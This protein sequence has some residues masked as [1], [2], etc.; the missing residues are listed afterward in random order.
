VVLATWLEG[1]SWAVGVLTGI[2]CVTIGQKIWSSQSKH[3]ACQPIQQKLHESDQRFYRVLDQAPYVMQLYAPDGTLR[4]TNRSWETLWGDSRAVLE[5]Y[6]VLQ[7]V[8]VLASGHLPSLQQVFA[9]EAVTLSP[10]V[11]KLAIDGDVGCARWLEGTAYPVKTD[12]GEVQEVVLVIKDITTRIQADPALESTEERLRYVNEALETKVTERTAALAQSNAMLQATLESTAEG[13]LVLDRQGKAVNFNARFIEMWGM[14][15]SVSEALRSGQ[16]E[17]MV[18]FAIEQLKDP[19]AFFQV[20]SERPNQLECETFDLLE[21]K[22]GRVLE[23]YARPQWLNDRC[24]GKVLSFRDAT[25]RR[26]AEEALHLRSQQTTAVIEIQQEI[27]ALSPNLDEVMALIVERIQELT[28]ASGAVI[29]MV[30]GDELVYRAANGVAAAQ[31]GLRLKIAT[32][33]S[34][35]C[36]ETGEILY[37]TDTETDPRVNLAAC[38]RMGIRSMVVV[39][40]SQQTG[41]TIGVLKAFS[42]MTEAFTQQS[43][44]T[45]QLLAGFLT[46]TLRLASQFQV[47]ENLLA[48]LQASEERYASVIAAMAE[49]VMLQNADGKVCTSNPSAEQ[50]LGLSAEQLVGRSSLDLNWHTTHE[51]GSPFP[52]EQHPAMVTLRTGEPCR[53][54]VMGIS[55]PDG[56]LTWISTNAQPLF[57]PDQSQPYAVVTSFSDITERREAQKYV[58]LLQSLALAV[59]Q[60]L[61]FSSAL[62]QVLRLVCE[63]T[64]W[65]YGEAWLF[66]SQSNALQCSPAYYINRDQKFDQLPQLDEFRAMSEAF[67]FSPGTGIP[68]RVWASQQPEWRED[69]SQELKHYFLQQSIVLQTNIKTAMGIPVVVDGQLLAVLVFFKFVAVREDAQ[70]LKS[71]A[72]IAAQLGAVLQRKQIEAA[73]RHS[74]AHNRAILQAIPDLLLWLRRDG[75]CLE[76]ILPKGSHAE[77]F[78]PICQNIA[79]VLPPELLQRQLQGIEQAITTGELQVREHSFIKQGKLV[80]EEVRI[81]AINDNEALVIVRDISDRKQTEANLRE[82]QQQ[83]SL[84][85]EGSGDGLWDWNIATSEVYFSPHWLKM[86]GYAEGDLA[87]S[88]ETWKE[89]LHPED[90]PWVVDCLNAHLNDPT[91]P[92]RFEYRVL[93]KSG[94]WKWIGNYGKVVARGEADQPTRMVGV[95]RDVNDRKQAELALQHSSEI[96]YRAIVEDQTELISRC[97]PDGT[98]TFVNQAYAL[99]FGRSSEALIGSC[100]QPLIFEADRER[101]AQLIASMNADNP[102]L[103]IENR[104]LVDGEVRW[105]LWHNRMLFDEHGQFIEFQSVGRDITDLKETEARLFHEKELAQVTLRSIGDAVI[106]T[107]RVGRIEYLN[108]IAEALTGWTQAEAQGMPLA[109]V[110]RIVHESTREP[111]PSPIEAALRDNQIVALANHTV[112]IARHGQEL[113]IEDSAAPIHDREGQTIGAVMVFHDVTQTRTLARQITWQASHD[114]LTGLVNRREFERRVE[115][116]LLLAQADHQVHA[117]CYLDLDR[118]K[119][120]N[121]TC[122]H[123]AGDELLRQVTTL[124]QEKTRKADTLARLGGDEF[125]LLLN[126]C[127]PEQALRVANALR[128]CVQAFRFVWQEQVFTIGVSI[129]L[130]S[131]DAESESLAEIISAADAA[132]YTAKHRGRNRVYVAQADDQER[133]QQRGEMQWVSRITQALESDH[134]CLYAQ[135]IAAITPV[136]QNGDHNG[137]HYEVLL[138]LRDE[139]GNLVPPMA[140]IPAAERYNLMHLIDR[141]VVRTL[142]ETWPTIVDDDRSIYAINLSGSSINDDQFIDFLHEQFALHPI[143]PQ[144]VCFEITET[145]AIANLTKASQFIQEL[146]GL[147]CRFALDDFGAGMSSFAYLKSLPV[148]YLKI[149]GSFI[150]NIVENSVDDAIVSAITHIGAVM[151]IRTIAEFVENDAILERIRALGIDYAQGYGIARP[152]PLIAR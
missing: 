107:D 32:S 114:A 103:V 61:D 50:I 46:N 60:S 133:L 29:E 17:A 27:A 12:M 66:C 41:N 54:V 73:L 104:V 95:H 10:F 147:G 25:E 96:R 89:L 125:G 111:V 33:L 150:R 35:R 143:S 110:F 31:V 140:F 82:S 131:I 128:E 62:E 100:Y 18:L 92:Y 28:H 13:I 16:A 130:I 44:Q 102:V 142:F 86:L 40:L 116:A 139:Q 127:T 146:Q 88:V 152:Q 47:K 109:E 19:E 132:C 129:G 126:Q 134:F 90:Q 49:G 42:A 37:C 76:C 23:C 149:D 120:V 53:N 11:Y 151:G 135:P 83:L 144:R 141:W 5:G 113:A 59:G 56:Q 84:A 22:H 4:Y 63:A 148:D 6:N 52:G 38:R 136:A 36:V 85:F 69:A 55:K 34:G 15:D 65:N 77:S 64:R 39:P 121:D 138:R 87:G 145:V 72:V 2:F 45:L 118:F 21:L 48:A 7:D 80:Y 98:I 79:E 101:V 3:L 74:E 26:Q 94:E 106:T 117:L 14:P 57:H 8:Q 81:A 108:P 70:L 93:T 24:I 122:G 20:T 9:G 71:L 99:Y 78:L 91:I 112:L 115:Q 124:L 43:I 137:D 123:V 1:I 58:Q 75:F 67:S 68:G 51:D 105:T 30:E 97:L 119:I